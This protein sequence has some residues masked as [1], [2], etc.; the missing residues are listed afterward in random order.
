MTLTW[1]DLHMHAEREGKVSA[2]NPG[3]VQ[4]ENI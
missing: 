4:P 1:I 2:I 3:H